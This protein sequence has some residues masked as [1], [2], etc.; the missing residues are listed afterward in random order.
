MYIYVVMVISKPRLGVYVE[1]G[2][3]GQQINIIS[4]VLV[5]ELPRLPTCL[6]AYLPYP[7]LPYLMPLRRSRTRLEVLNLLFELFYTSA[8]SLRLL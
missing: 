3:G 2:K 5:L 6:P 8:E 7:I 4:F 1:K